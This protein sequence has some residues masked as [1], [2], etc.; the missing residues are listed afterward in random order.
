MEDHNQLYKEKRILRIAFILSL[1]T[2]I[3]ELVG[4]V[5]THSQ[6]VFTDS[7]YDLADLLMLLPFMILLPKLYKPVSEKWPFGMSQI[8]PLFVILRCCVIL[9]LDVLL[10]YDSAKMIF[11]GGHLVN[12]TTVASFEFGMALTCILI[13]FILM[14]LCRN[15]MS[16]TLSSELYVWKVDAYSTAGVGAAFII[17]IIVQHTPL[18]LI[19]PYID[20]SVAIIIA[21]ALIAEP[22]TM[23]RDSVRSL[24]LVA[25]DPEMSEKVRS[26]A[27]AELIRYNM[28]IDF[29]DIVRTGRK[30]WIEIYIVPENNILD[31]RM[32]K[33]AR[34]SITSK[35][36]AEYD[37]ITVELTPELE[38]VEGN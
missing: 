6:A 2:L 13:Y 17:Q 15:F 23:I 8:E 30:T 22:V 26:I 29:L 16:P 35:L 21:L 10:I 25:P 1:I 36:A 9:V 31:L 7:I 38:K 28:T 32:L 3:A 33:S 12:A 37:D 27:E 5:V 14:R 34:D 4:A 18:S 19:A 11:S 24:I 20:P